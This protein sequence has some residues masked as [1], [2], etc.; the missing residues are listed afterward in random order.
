M[1]E[2][3]ILHVNTIIQH[4]YIALSPTDNPLAQS[5]YHMV[6]SLPCCAVPSEVSSPSTWYAVVPETNFP[7]AHQLLAIT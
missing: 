4:S 3:Y 2:S 6:S 1:K 5:N 7:L